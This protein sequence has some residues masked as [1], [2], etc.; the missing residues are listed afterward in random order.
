MLIACDLFGRNVGTGLERK[1]GGRARNNIPIE[2]IQHIRRQFK[3][4]T[5]CG[6]TT[7]NTNKNENE[8]YIIS[9]HAQ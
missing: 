1:P 7:K 9:S 8:R 2:R 5:H 4:R 3:W 6:K